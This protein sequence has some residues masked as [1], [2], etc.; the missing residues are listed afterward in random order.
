MKKILSLVLAGM[1]VMGTTAM[2]QVETVDDVMAI[3]TLINEEVK[4]YSI[5]Q[6]DSEFTVILSENSSTGY[7]WSYTISNEDLVE[8]VGETTIVADEV[9]LGSPYEKR[10]TF[11]VLDDGVS[12]IKFVNER[13]FSDELAAES[14][15]LL[16]YKREESII[17]EEDQI[18]YAMDTNQPTLYTLS[19]TATYNGIE[20]N[21]DISVQQIDGITMIPLRATLEAMGYTVTWVQ[22]TKSVEINKG[23]QWTSISIGKNAYFRNRMAAH[24]LSSGPVIV[25]NRTLVPVEFFADI[26]GNGIEVDSQKINFLESEAVIHRGYI[27]SIT[28]DETGTKTI[29]LTTDLSSESIELQTIIHTSSAYTFYHKEIVEG[30]YVQVVGSMV[31]TMSMPGQTSGYIVY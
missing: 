5:E 30:S 6:N 27:K 25:N 11:K 21:A 12:T 15:D 29:T 14:F 2:A 9:L 28:M 1:M 8:F 24:E 10:L 3:P 20:I 16:V 4:S 13:A 18:V 7:M 17:V 26:I 31:M 22:E 23:A 19:E